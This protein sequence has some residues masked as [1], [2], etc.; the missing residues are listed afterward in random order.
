MTTS[1]RGEYSPPA[2]SLPPGSMP[3]VTSTTQTSGGVYGRRAG[4]RTPGCVHPAELLLQ[5]GDLV[6]QPGG[7]LELQLGRRRV[8]LVGEL[9]DQVGQVRRAASRRARPRARPTLAAPRRQ[10]RHRRLAAGLL[11]P[12]ATEQLLGVGVLAGEQVGDVGDLLAQRLRVDAV[13]ACCRR[14]AWPGAGW[15]RRSPAPSTA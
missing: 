2:A 11:A 6:A 12:A 7:Q 13:L 15:S 10:A 9:L 1:P 3:R 4:Q 14:P 5:L 8:H